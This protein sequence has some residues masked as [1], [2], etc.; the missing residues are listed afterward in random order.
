M[1]KY[2][3]H[4]TGNIEPAKESVT[5]HGKYNPY[6]LD[7]TFSHIFCTCGNNLFRVYLSDYPE[8]RCICS[9]CDEKYLIYDV[10]FYPASTG[11]DPGKGRFNKWVSKTGKDVFQVIAG[12]LY[13]EDPDDRDDIDWF[14]LITIDPDTYEYVEVVNLNQ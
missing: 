1:K 10:S 2:P 12:W 3:S 9:A 7:N 8:V 14:V 13:P 6:I 5:V 11:Y 4:Y